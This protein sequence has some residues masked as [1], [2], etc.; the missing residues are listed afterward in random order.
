MMRYLFNWKRRRM[1]RRVLKR[2]GYTCQKCGNTENLIVH[3]LSF[4][5]GVDI[6]NCP[7]DE[8]ITH[9]RDCLDYEMEAKNQLDAD[10]LQMQLAGIN[11]SEIAK[12]Y[13]C[14]R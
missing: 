2:D 10:I 12:K 7:E 8:L 9:C 5:K 14:S 3:G 4:H 6:I 11:P 1:A 13:D